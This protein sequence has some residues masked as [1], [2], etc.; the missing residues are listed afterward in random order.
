MATTTSKRLCSGIA[1]D[2]LATIYTATAAKT[3]I[4]KAITLC[5][6]SIQTVNITMTFDGIYVLKLHSITSY[7]T[8]TIPFIDQV[9]EA[10][11]LIQ[12]QASI[13]SA[14]NYYISGKEVD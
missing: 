12:I 3:T 11:D 1:S 4:I 9:L 10:G 7:D 14:V 5:N 6:T 13:T 2:S 8:L